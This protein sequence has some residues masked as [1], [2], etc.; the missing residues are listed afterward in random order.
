MAMSLVRRRPDSG[1]GTTNEL[2]VVDNLTRL[3]NRRYFDSRLEEELS[4]A[5]RYESPLSVLFI[6]LQGYDQ[7]GRAF[8]TLRAE[9]TLR[10]AADIIR[11]TVRKADIVTRFDACTFGLV[12]PHTGVQAEVVAARLVR[13][14]GEWIVDEGHESGRAPIVLRMG[15]ASYAVD[16]DEAATIVTRAMERVG[17]VA[18]PDY[19]ALAA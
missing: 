5:S 9:E 11:S 10:Q 2:S 6:E 3:Y 13:K 17:P 14:L 8:G 18:L 12:L 1:S 16:A 7:I 4:R 19:S 15:W